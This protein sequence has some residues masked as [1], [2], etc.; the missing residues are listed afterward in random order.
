MRKIDLTGQRF[1]RLTALR[2]TR[3]NGRTAWECVCECGNVKV[4]DTGKLSSCHTVS[5][6]C[7]RWGDKKPN[8]TGQ[9]FT[10]L[11]ALK[12]TVK[13][14]RTAWECI[15]ECGN[16]V[17]IITGDLLRGHAKSCG[18]LH[19]EVNKEGSITHG[20][21]KTTEYATW[22]H[23]NARC[24]NQNEKSYKNYGG[25][26]IKV[27]DR[28]RDSFENFISDMGTKPETNMSIER[29]DNDGD[30]CLENCKWGTA[31]EQARNKRT[32]S[33]N[34]IGIKGI[35]FKKDNTYVARIHTDGKSVYLGTFDVLKDAVAARQEAEARY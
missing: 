16:A 19:I 26:G 33:N 9:R 12:E 23:V 17:V 35:S 11:T 28:W 34:R 14:G 3:R 22:C 2:P 31:F 4:I 7:I 21:S 10:R 15:C 6:G 32:N 18:C 20:L 29:I 25:R 30:Y 5:C 8:L 24:S 27:C 1:G 13:N